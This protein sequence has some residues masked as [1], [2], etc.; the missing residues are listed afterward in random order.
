MIAAA[1]TARRVTNGPF[2]IEPI[3]FWRALSHTSA[4][5]GTGNTKLKTT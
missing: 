2:A 1:A 3:V 5:T 4:I